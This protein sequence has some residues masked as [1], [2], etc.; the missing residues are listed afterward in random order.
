MA[1]TSQKKGKVS[2]KSGVFYGQAKKLAVN[3]RQR[4][5]LIVNDSQAV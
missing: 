1:S 5:G 2:K 3:H 4:R